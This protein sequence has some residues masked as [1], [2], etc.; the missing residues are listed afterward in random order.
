MPRVVVKTERCKA[1][2]F[3]I[4]F[5]PQ[6]A[7]AMSNDFNIRGVHYACLLD[8]KKCTGCGI[9]GLVCPDVAVEVYR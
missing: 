7:L 4:A 1:C 8:E 2:G 9:C 5:C 3:C 6:K